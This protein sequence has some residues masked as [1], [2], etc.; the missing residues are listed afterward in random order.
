MFPAIPEDKINKLSNEVQAIR[1][2]ARMLIPTIRNQKQ[3]KQR[4]HAIVRAA[5]RYFYSEKE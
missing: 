4:T 1:R 3:W 2:E 5:V